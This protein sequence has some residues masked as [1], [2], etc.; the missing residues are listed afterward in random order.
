MLSSHRHPC[1]YP[2]PALS[3]P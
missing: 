3:L 2:P 1:R